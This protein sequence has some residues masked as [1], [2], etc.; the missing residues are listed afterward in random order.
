M[1]ATTEANVASFIDPWEAL[2]LV[3]PEVFD[4]FDLEAVP[5]KDRERV[6]RMIP[7]RDFA[8][9][10]V[11]PWDGSYVSRMIDG[12]RDLDVFGAAL[13]QWPTQTFNILLFGPSGAA[14]TLSAQAFAAAHRLPYVRV[15][16]NGGLDPSIMWGNYVKDEVT[17]EWTWEHS[18]LSL[19]LQHGGVVMLDEVNMASPR[20]T[21]AFNEC[22]DFGRQFTVTL[23]GSRVFDIHPAVAW[24]GSMN[25]GYDGTARL[26]FA[27]RRRFSWPIQ[28]DYDPAVE[29]VLVP[30]PTLADFAKAVRAMP[31]VR[32]DLS[33]DTLVKFID[34]AHMLTPD[35]A[36]GRLLDLFDS[37]ERNGVALALEMRLPSILS[38]LG[39]GEAKVEDPAPAEDPATL[40]EY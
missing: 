31:E 2:G 13:S 1:T 4:S 16:V 38:E 36:K 35:F 6:R 23:L 17:G 10:D 3:R 7:S 18:D 32:S 33:T 15:P 34:S 19:I 24:F 40:P 11:H 12:V 29:S 37:S 8:P 20:I 30:S 5:E 14:K 9:T 21:T 28:W 25:P 26:N 22:L 39:L 27:L